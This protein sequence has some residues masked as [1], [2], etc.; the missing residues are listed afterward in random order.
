MVVV[1]FVGS[2]L[3]NGCGYPHCQMCSPLVIAVGILKVQENQPYRLWPRQVN[4]KHIY[5]LTFAIVVSH[6]YVFETSRFAN[7]DLPLILC[8]IRASSYLL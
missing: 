2:E 3:M 5:V 4:R 1:M 8:Y 7:L 6:Q